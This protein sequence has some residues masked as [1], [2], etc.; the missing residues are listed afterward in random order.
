[1]PKNLVIIAGPNGSGK[2]TFAN[3]YVKLLGYHYLSADD[4]A[5]RL[6]PQLVKNVKIEETLLKLFWHEDLTDE[7]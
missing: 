3:E 1:M 4:I 2:T 7:N 5:A 6:S